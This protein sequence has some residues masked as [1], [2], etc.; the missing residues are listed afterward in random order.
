[1]EFI[2]A[3]LPGV[4]V[5]QPKVFPDARGFFLETYHARRFA[6]HGITLP[7]VQDNHSKSAGGTLRGLHAQ[8]G[9]PQ[10]KLVRAIAGE[11]FDVAVDI[12]RGSPTYKKWFGVV[13]SAERHNMCFV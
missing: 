11:I 9:H 12:R 3:P 6:E 2:E 4:L 5:V 1:M 8:L 7:F 10:G 13:L